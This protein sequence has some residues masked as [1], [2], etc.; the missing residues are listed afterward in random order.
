M[1]TPACPPSPLSVIYRSYIS[2]LPAWSN[3][4]QG[5]TTYQRLHSPVQ[6]MSVVPSEL[7]VNALER[8]VAVRLRLLDPVFKQ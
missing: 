8:R 6:G 5:R 3:L 1:Q 7:G 2:V 4:R